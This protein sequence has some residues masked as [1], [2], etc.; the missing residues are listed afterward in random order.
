MIDDVSRLVPLRL[1]WNE[2]VINRRRWRVV[3]RPVRFY[4]DKA[5]LFFQLCFR[6]LIRSRRTF[7]R[8]YS[9]LNSFI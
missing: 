5:Q 8:I 4:S 3:A 7:S 6:F 9:L 2:R 1:E